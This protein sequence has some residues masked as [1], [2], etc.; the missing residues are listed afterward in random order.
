MNNRDASRQ[1][2]LLFTY[3]RITRII[4]EY[5]ALHDAQFVTRFVSDPPQS[6][7]VVFKSDFDHV[8]R[9]GKRRARDVLFNYLS[10]DLNNISLD[11]A[12]PLVENHPMTMRRPV[13]C[14]ALRVIYRCPS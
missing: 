13:E 7:I 12:K 1:A 5:T 3:T 10:L 9:V 6:L 8:V 11:F 4:Y 14:T 2:L